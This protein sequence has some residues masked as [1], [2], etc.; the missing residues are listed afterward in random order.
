MAT[1]VLQ[2]LMDPLQSRAEWVHQMKITIGSLLA[3]SV[4][5]IP[6]FVRDSLKLSNRFVGP[7]VRLHQ[8]I[9]SVDRSD[10]TALQFREGDF[11][12][13]LAKDFNAMTSRLRNETPAD[14]GVEQLQ[15]VVSSHAD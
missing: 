12:D 5:L 8:F 15:E 7:I 11:W 10:D 2:F 14:G 6:V 4:C 3:V 13:S 1:V 9:Q